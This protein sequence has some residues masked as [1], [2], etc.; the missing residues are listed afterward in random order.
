MAKWVLEYVALH[1][2]LD[3]AKVAVVEDEI[4]WLRLILRR[5]RLNMSGN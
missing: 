1:H 3:N 2:K 5:A 4:D